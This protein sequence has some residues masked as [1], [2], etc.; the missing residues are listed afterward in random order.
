MRQSWK[1][2]ALH[3]FLHTQLCRECMG[4]KCKKMRV[5]VCRIAWERAWLVLS[6]HRAD[7]GTF[8]EKGEAFLAGRDSCRGA[9][10]SWE[11][12]SGDGVSAEIRLN[13]TNA[14]NS[15]QLQPGDYLLFLTAADWT[16]PVPVGADGETELPGE[17]SFS[18]DRNRGRYTVRT[19]RSPQGQLLIH[20]EDKVS[21]PSKGFRGLYQKA[22][23]SFL[24]LEY[25]A[26]RSFIRPEKG[27]KR[28]LFM[29]EQNE[30]LAGNLQAVKDRLS[31]RGL[32]D[33]FSLSDSC[34]VTV[35][36]EHLGFGS[37][38][39]TVRKLAEADYLF[40]DDH[41]PVLDWLKLDEGT[42]V[43]QLWHG[44]VGF[45]DSGYT[46]WGHGG[47][48]PPDSAYRQIHWGVCASEADRDVFA[49]LW[50]IGRERILPAGMPRLDALLDPG[51]AR[52]M[53]EAAVLRF[54]QTK[55]KKV[56]LYAPTYRG[57]NR[58]D[59]HFPFD[60]VDFRKWYEACGE[61]WVVL[62]RMHPWVK[63]KP[64]VPEDCRDRLID[65]G[66]AGNAMDLFGLADLLVTDYSS[67]IFEFASQKKPMLFYAFD[68]ADY[69][70]D[71]GIHGDYRE[72][73]PGKVTETFS[74][75][76]EAVRQRDFEE[77]K[78]AAY[79]ARHLERLD[80]YSTDR[81]IDWFLLDTVPEHY[82]LER[83]KAEQKAAGIGR[84]IQ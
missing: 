81:V 65:A 33:R 58:L 37:W 83:E 35:T 55:G 57:K 18:Y 4:V 71:R 25:R 40:L 41:A 54:P 51:K 82:L 27:K 22:M 19:E 23:H 9:Q 5:T 36:R 70:A 80:A 38:V 52:K 1:R 79:R 61:E 29:S 45:K 46:R 74:E 20:T 76:L 69:Q 31:E 78:A 75:L 77:E 26:C 32:T 62:L 21:G 66:G 34:R 42:S 2:E 48:L 49:E 15:R 7:G 60:S 44:G 30:S 28:I 53:R 63:E 3:C 14:G 43:I 39:K 8:P 47:S 50:G 59:A 13:I 73:A 16:E 67:A 6:L 72:L 12:S 68:L 10:A 64:P 84:R 17:V 56:L 24:R 11:R